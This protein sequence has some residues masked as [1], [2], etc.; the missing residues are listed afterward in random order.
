M[1]GNV[2]TGKDLSLAD[3]AART[4]SDIADLAADPNNASLK[5]RPG[6]GIKISEGVYQA[7]P[8]NGIALSTIV[9]M[10]GLKSVDAL[11][12]ANPQWHGNLQ[13]PLKYPNAIYLPSTTYAAGSTTGVATLATVASYFGVNLTTLAVLNADLLGIF[14]DDQY[15]TVTGGPYT[16]T[17]TVP[18]GVAALTAK[19]PKAAPT[20]AY[21]TGYGQTLLANNFSILGYRIA[22]NKFFRR[23]N[24]GMPVGP[25]PAA[26]SA[27]PSQDKVR[28]ASA[29]ETWEFHQ[30]IPYADSAEV[31]PAASAGI[32]PDSSGD[33]YRGLGSILQAE[34]TWQDYFGNTLISK[35]DLG[36]KAPYN[37]PP[38][39]VGYT[40]A[41]IGV[42]QWP[43]VSAA[44]RVRRGADGQ[45]ALELPL[46][47]DQSA[48]QG[49][50]KATATG[51][52]TLRV[53]FTGPLDPT[54]SL[55][56]S[57]YR[58]DGKTAI[59]SAATGPTEYSVI[60]TL[61]SGQSL[62]DGEH[63]LTVSGVLAAAVTG[64][65][66]QQSYDGSAGFTY[67]EDPNRHTSTVTDRATRDLSRYTTVYYQ[68]ND[69]NGISA[70]VTTSLL[71]DPVRLGD[72]QWSVLLGWLFTE[73]ASIYAYLYAR[74]IG[75]AEAPLPQSTHT[76]AV[77]LD[78]AK[79]NQK[80]I[81][82]L[83][84][85][86]TLARTGGSVLGNLQT[87]P[88]IRV[89]STAL[90]PLTDPLKQEEKASA[91][92]PGQEE[93][94][95]TLGLAAFAH[96]FE[97]AL[98]VPG[99]YRLKVAGGVNRHA[100]APAS[101][102]A[103]LWAVRLGDTAPDAPAQPISFKVTNVN[104]P[105]LF[106]PRPLSNQ[107]QSRTAVPI[108]EYTR[109]IGIAP[110]DHPTYKLDFA[111][112]DMDL[113]GRTLLAAVDEILAPQFTAAIQ[114]V[115]KDVAGD[116][117]LVKIL[118][119]K[120]KLAD[121]VAQWMIPLYAAQNPPDPAAVREAFRQQLLS[122]LSSAYDTRAAIQFSAAVKAA[123]TETGATE[124]PRL[125]GGIVDLVGQS[126][127][128]GERRSEIGLTS[129]KLSLADSPAAPL[130][131]LLSA[132]ET[133]DRDGAVV[134]SVDL[135]LR[136]TGESIE[137]QISAP[138]GIPG[139][140]ASS[141]LSFVTQDDT[142]A[143]SAH[144][145]S[146]PVPL[147]LRSFPAAPNITRQTGVAD[148]EESADLSALTRWTYAFNWSLPFH[149]VQDK[150]HGRV[151]FNLA[152]TAAPEQAD[153]F[154]ALAEFV[155][156]YPRVLADLETIVAGIDA[157]QQTPETLKDASVALESFIELLSRVSST[158]GET[159]L[160]VAT[161]APAL[162]GADTLTY[163]FQI[164]EDSI[165]LDDPTDPNQK[166]SALLVTIDGALPAGVST[167]V[168]DID[169]DHY[170][171]QRYE[172]DTSPPSLIKYVYVTREAPHHYL[173]LAQS[174]TI[175][176]RILTLPSLDVMQRQ[177]AWS[178]VLIKRNEEIIS[179]H[180]TAEPFV[181]TTAEV[182]FAE[183]LLPTIDAQA[184]IN[185]ATLG[186]DGPQRSL[187]AQ[188]NALFTSLF[189]TLP[190]DVSQAS[191][192]VET[193]YAYRLHP[194][195]DMVELPLF[196]QPPLTVPVHAGASGVPATMINNWVGAITTWFASAK[197]KGTE[198][199]LHFDLAIMSTLTAQPMPLLRLRNL[200]LALT[201]I[202]PPL[203]TS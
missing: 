113:W 105:D 108:Y 183:P 129:P 123:I 17:A 138:P 119:Q 198:G 159:G 76:I 141:W 56:A 196:F 144:L 48:Y 13:D 45:P 172:K 187:Q 39:L 16:R 60:L 104:Q 195:L 4:Y 120:E 14:A 128:E 1:E 164:T 12:T 142:G 80:Q 112:V 63:V 127:P 143:L 20:Q 70:T 121:A 82:E 114:I 8:G 118:A 168:L 72:G 101:D 10:F 34:Y 133:V 169:P 178:S 15:M 177:D 86:L 11:N 117:F 67:P 88:G 139:Y 22:G 170:E 124:P 165:E 191:I 41:L 5:L 68:L 110:I 160:A 126:L 152:A 146:F 161:P 188:L 184:P 137:H 69:S 71:A 91:G 55:T 94:T 149:Y 179:G 136:W 156:V 203:A 51:S 87:T 32:L 100:V 173:T 131:I 33:P 26:G 49:L 25:T 6:I 145:G 193:L 52:T 64:S 23:S 130:A 31:V 65:S 2:Q 148:H 19:R 81:F 42:S 61:V 99:T 58:L 134:G 21:G 122:R 151:E 182:R 150:V 96:D 158:F 192:Q 79:V 186:T 7:P 3:V 202:V 190:A 109:G 29:T 155:T 200:S 35:F 92:N 175:P 50:N 147:V 102:G 36:Q 199:V 194:D 53:D 176:G 103:S 166:V 66:T 189:A 201:D 83:T 9:G 93:Q 106:A 197:P 84:A 154:P 44:W 27:N 132:P 140:L 54:T 153:S 125:S 43:A 135:D 111:D 37:Q 181:Y 97:L 30:S 115:D 74:A 107:L 185:I 116:G 163:A 77:P 59:E 18:P 75:Q 162:A 57:N 180:P 47:F 157:K 24:S 95:D 167:A 174:Q 46:A 73:G 171:P 40:D 62:S 90:A 98:S 78:P 28:I 38:V 89:A 85:S